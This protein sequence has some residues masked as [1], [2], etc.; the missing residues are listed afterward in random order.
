MTLDEQY[1]YMRETVLDRIN[2]WE[3]MYTFFD[4]LI[5]RAKLNP[6]LPIMANAAF[7]MHAFMYAMREAP[8]EGDIK[9][10]ADR[11]LRIMVYEGQSKMGVTFS[12]VSEEELTKEIGARL[13]EAYVT[14]VADDVLAQAVAEKPKGPLH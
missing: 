5:E 6:V 12:L 8:E 1:A 10:L 9:K 4:E 13:I 2:S 14:R 7:I 11:M 3:D